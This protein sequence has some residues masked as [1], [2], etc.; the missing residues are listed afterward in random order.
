M[1][2]TPLMRVC[3]VLLESVAQR[4]G[5]VPASGRGALYDAS[6]APKVDLAEYIGRWCEY[7]ETGDAEVVCAVVFVDRLCTAAGLTLSLRNVHRVILAAMLVATK[8]REER[9]FKMSY[10]ARVGGVS[11][12]EISRLETCLIQDIEWELHVDEHLARKYLQK[13][14]RH[15]H[16][17]TEEKPA[18]RRNQDAAAQPARG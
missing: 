6:K 7:T 16:W 18:R 3:A 8:W 15:P 12:D 17:Q 2:V 9:P 14:R 11:M 13:F 4:A 5:D 1:P 10:Y